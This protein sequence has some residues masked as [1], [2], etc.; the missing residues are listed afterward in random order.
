MSDLT[1]RL[2]HLFVAV[3]D[4]Q[5]CHLNLQYLVSGFSSGVDR[6]VLIHFG[7]HLGEKARMICETESF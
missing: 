7:Y 2:G 3:D 5:F 6:S 4:S 1:F